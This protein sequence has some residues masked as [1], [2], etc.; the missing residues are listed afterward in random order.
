MGRFL[1][2]NFL[3]ALRVTYASLNAL[4][5]SKAASIVNVSAGGVMPV[6]GPLAHYV[7]A[8]AA[9]NSFSKAL[10]KEL[11]AEKIRVNIVTPGPVITPG[12]DEVRDVISKALGM[13]A[14]AYFAQVP[15]GRAGVAADIAEMIAFLS[16]DRA[17]WITGHDHFVSGGWGELAG[18]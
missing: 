16:S 7:A 14:E 17:S 9:L 3:A 2:I 15:L 10:A 13:P 4:K 12:A 1:N 11:A 8:K 6:G 5:Q 18:S